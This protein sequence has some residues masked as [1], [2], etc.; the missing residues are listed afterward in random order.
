MK[1]SFTIIMCLLITLCLTL[2]ITQ[3]PFCFYEEY[4]IDTLYHVAKTHR[5]MNGEYFID[6][7]MGTQTVYPA[8]FHLIFGKINNLLLMDTFTMVHFWGV[9]IYTLTYLS[10]VY[11]GYTV[12]RSWEW[13][14]L[15]IFSYSLL[16]Y[17]P[18]TR[19]FLYQ[20]PATFSFPFIIFGF[21]LSIE[22]IKQKPFLSRLAGSMLCFSLGINIWWFNL[23]A[24]APYL[25]VLFLY[26]KK[27]ISFSFRNSSV[28]FI[29]LLL[30]TIVTILHIHTV[31]EI[32]PYY[33]EHKQKQP[34]PLIDVLKTS[35]IGFITRGTAFYTETIAP[36]KWEHFDRIGTMAYI[37]DYLDAFY[38]FA[39]TIPGNIIIITLSLLF[40]FKNNSKVDTQKNSIYLGVLFFSSY[41][42]LFFS[43]F[44]LLSGNGAHQYRVQ[45][46]SQILMFLYVLKVF[47]LQNHNYI[48]KTS[49]K[50]LAG[51]GTICTIYLYL[52]KPWL[53]NKDWKMLREEDQMVVEF[54]KTIPNHSQKRIFMTEKS[55]AQIV[56]FIPFYSFVANQNG[57]YYFADPYH[58]D[59]YAEDYEA[60]KELKDGWINRLKDHQTEYIIINAKSQQE[61]RL[62]EK[63]QT[64]SEIVYDNDKWIVLKL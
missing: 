44:I 50:I 10:L 57:R 9:I 8:F 19:M 51:L 20:G 3:P 45:F 13:T 55:Y 40:F 4:C 11:L 42:T 25:L 46:Y 32:I 60:I 39:I 56:P 14:A 12:Y 35:V 64:I 28:V 29:A 16:I 49:F 47:Q 6:P 17:V 53:I 2:M 21:A 41:L 27:K 1:I 59:L 26:F 30:P 61:Q 7:F 38:V 63:F 52:H 24:V 22:Y 58:S 36:W 34:I 23:F 48:Y 43:F 37:R 15:F 18:T 62:I 33:L 5:V 31:R 54:I